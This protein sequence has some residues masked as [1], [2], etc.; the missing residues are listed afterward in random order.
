MENVNQALSGCK[1]RDSNDVTTLQLVQVTV[2]F[3]SN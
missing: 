3:S 1:G 2:P